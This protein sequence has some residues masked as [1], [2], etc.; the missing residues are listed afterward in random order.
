METLGDSGN[1]MHNSYVYKTFFRNTKDCLP[2][3]ENFGSSML[4]TLVLY[5]GFLTFFIFELHWSFLWTHNELLVYTPL[6]MASMMSL[7][8]HWY[9]KKK[10]R[11]QNIT[12]RVKTK[13][14][15]SRIKKKCN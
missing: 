15:T 3:E 4:F 9:L 10:T 7:F 1:Y 11:L 2:H 13:T 12:N 5:I 8:T 14:Y 6:N